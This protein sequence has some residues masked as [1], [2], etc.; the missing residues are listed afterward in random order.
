LRIGDIRID[1]AEGDILVFRRSIESE[2]VECVFNLGPAE[3]DSSVLL[4]E[5]EEVL[6]TVGMQDA[7]LGGMPPFSCRVSRL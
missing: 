4:V 5:P 6:F 3:Q 2:T 1:V 7:T